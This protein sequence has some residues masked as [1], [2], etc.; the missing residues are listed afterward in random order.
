MKIRLHR[1]F[2]ALALPLLAA[3]PAAAQDR[4]CDPG[5]ESCRDI[6]ITYIRNETVAI[7]VAFW[8]MEDS[9]YTT[10]LIRKHQAGVPVRVLIDTRANSTYPLN[11]DRLA[12]LQAA[13]IP[14]RRRLTN[15]ILHWK[16]MLFEGQNVVQFS[17]AN[18]SADAWRPAT[19]TNYENYTDEAI[20]FTSDDAIVNSFRTKFDDQ[21]VDTTSWT[22]YANITTPLTRRYDIYPK[23]PSLNFPP[24]ENYRTRSINAYKAEKRKIDVIMYRITDRQHTDN[25]LAAVAR[26]I[27]VRLISEPKQYRDVSRMWHAWNIDRLYMG[28]VQIKH[29]SHAGLNHQ[30]SVILYDQNG[31]AAG[32]QSMAIFGSSNWTSPSASGQLEHNI[33]TTKPYVTNW[34]I[35]QFERK[36]NNSG[37][38]EENEPFVPLPPDAPT[39]PTPA[40]GVTGVGTSNVTF[41]WFGGPWAHLYDF[42]LDTNPDPT[43]LVAPDLAESASKTATST[44]SFVYTGT[45]QPGTT[46]YWKV[47]GKTMALQTKSSP[48]WSFTTTGSAPPPP[49]PSGSGEIVVWASNATARAG[50]WILE[51]DVTAAGGRKMRHPNAGAAKVASASASPANYFELTFDAEANRGYRLWIRGKAD[52]NQWAN[53]S[54]FVQFSGSVTSGGSPTWR[55]GTT[56]AT[57]INLEECNGCGVSNWGWQD[58]GYGN[59][60]LG[61]LVYFA[62]TG[63]QTI[64][65]QT[66]EDG[67]SIDQVVLSPETFLTARPGAA[68]NDTTI[69]GETD[70][71]GGGEEPPPP[72]PDPSGDPGDVVLHAGAASP[73]VAGGWRIES[74]ASAA[75]G[76]LVRHP[77]AGAAKQASALASPTHY[78]ELTFDADAGKA[79]RLWIRGRADGNYWG[80]DSVFVQFSGSVD[81]NG[82]ARWR[83]GTTAAAEVN[84]ED[85]SGCGLSGWG[86]QDNGWGVNVMG[87]LVYFAASGP[88]TI[89][90]QTREDG[91]AIDQVVVSSSM[92]VNDAPGALKN[93]TTILSPTP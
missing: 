22:N 18:Y 66:R 72:P 32:D 82:A 1:L 11:A 39:N 57:E 19:T 54:V 21:W 79:Y 33:F 24:A 69:L 90:I 92:F 28:G 47:V 76:K 4:L 38:I 78:V 15:Y 59:N 16:M 93:D 53:D 36:W 26:G 41:K 67:L 85:C 51:N 65:F 68:K 3:A 42:Y 8:F 70:G 77:N 9:R 63:P 35:D 5:D 88:Q 44:F 56:S 87:P 52:S 45:L 14:M 81:A 20:Y 29:R 30:K 10:E 73:V 27:P 25:I 74:D 61:P 84:L 31:T 48:V 64:R 55:I 12:E 75:S 49:P 6:L 60:V 80:N 89:R 91:L 34:L 23:D 58:N 43:T 40:L 46:Y 62:S 50:A 7:D 13:G 37:G 2:L 17:G 86:W 83:I 71:G